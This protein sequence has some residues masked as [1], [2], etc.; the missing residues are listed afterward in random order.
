MEL[1]GT[2]KF[3]TIH[4][5]GNREGTGTVEQINRTDIKVLGGIAYHYIIDL[6]GHIIPNLPLRFK[7]RHVGNNNSNNIGVCYIGGC[8]KDL[9]PKDTRTPEQTAALIKLMRDLRKQ[10]PGVVFKGHRDWSPDKNKNGKIDK[11]EWVKI[12]PCFEV[13]ELEKLAFPPPVSKGGK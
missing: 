2:P 8:D 5:S 3:V 1:L 7:G 11:F 6:K 13:S 10:F 9:K 4:C 12:C